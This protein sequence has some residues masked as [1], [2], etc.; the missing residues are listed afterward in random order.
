MWLMKKT[1]NFHF[2]IIT[3][4]ASYSFA[5]DFQVVVAKRDNF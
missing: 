3:Q 5:I 4:N 2:Y 1:M